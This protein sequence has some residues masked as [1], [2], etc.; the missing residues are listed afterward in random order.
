MSTITT[1]KLEESHEE[2]NNAY[3][4]PSYSRMNPIQV[5]IETIHPHHHYPTGTSTSTTGSI[6]TRTSNETTM[7]H[8]DNNHFISFVIIGIVLLYSTFL[9]LLKK[10]K[11]SNNENHTNNNEMNNIKNGNWIIKLW[12]VTIPQ[13]I[14]SNF[15]QAW[16]EINNNDDED[17]DD[18]NN[19]DDGCD[20]YGHNEDT[21]K[22]ELDASNFTQT[23][24]YNYT[25]NN[26]TMLQN[27]LDR[28]TYCYEWMWYILYYTIDIVFDWSTFLVG[29]AVGGTNR[30][31]ASNSAVGTTTA[32]NYRSSC[33]S[34]M[35][36][37]NGVGTKSSNNESRKR[38][39]LA[40]YSKNS[41]PMLEEVTT[42]PCL[43]NQQDHKEELQQ[44]QQH[45]NN[46]NTRITKKQDIQS[47]T[48]NGGSMTASSGTQSPTT[49]PILQPSTIE[50]NTN[51]EPA[52]LNDKDYPSGW[53]VYD[54]IWGEVVPRESLA[55]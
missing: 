26:N 55:H 8:W 37:T 34:S 47:K 54:P 45:S 1:N 3:P 21:K 5:N 17:N 15:K 12:T 48:Y 44:H 39:F 36:K 13:F 29:G 19:D 10:A 53:L 38:D 30:V 4:P 28:M 27:I 22:Q 25:H 7:N 6:Y 2:N 40:S 50:Y 24:N 35:T 23:M 51:I 14:S 41:T 43:R 18:D 11:N 42:T 32:T 31:I 46:N 9:L 33:S 52:F 16:D 20:N 49:T